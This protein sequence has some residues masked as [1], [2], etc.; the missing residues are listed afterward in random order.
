MLLSRNE[1]RMTVHSVYTSVSETPGISVSGIGPC[2]GCR[3]RNVQCFCNVRATS[4]DTAC[5][6]AC[7][8]SSS[9]AAISS[10]VF[11]D[12]TIHGTTSFL[13][14]V[15][16][17]P[18][19]T[20]DAVY[21]SLV[22]EGPAAIETLSVSGA[23]QA[24]GGAVFY[25]P[26][27]LD[28]GDSSGPGFI[29]GTAPSGVALTVF[30]NTNLSGGSLWASDVSASGALSVM[31]PVSLGGALSVSGPVT[32]GDSLA[33]SSEASFCGALGVSGTASFSGSFVVSGTALVTGPLTLSGGFGIGILE[34]SAVS[35]TYLSAQTISAA[36]AQA[37]VFTMAEGDVTM[38]LSAASIY[39][40]GTAVFQS[41]V[42]VESTLAVSGMSYLASANVSGTSCFAGPVKVSGGLQVVGGSL[43]MGAGQ[44]LNL[45][46]SG[47]SLRLGTASNQ[48]YF[49]VQG[50]AVP[51][52][53]DV[54]GG[55]LS[56]LTAYSETAELVPDALS[57]YSGTPAMLTL[58]TAG[59]YLINVAWE[60]GPESDSP[61]FTAALQ[62]VVV[63]FCPQGTTAYLN[64]K[65]LGFSTT[66]CSGIGTSYLSTNDT[67]MYACPPTSSLQ[68]FPQISIQTGAGTAGLVYQKAS[69]IAMRFC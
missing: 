56:S 64:Q 27:S 14:S 13:G 39:V 68:I 63:G 65:T 12:V 23:L 35:T 37:T 6:Y 34:A 22:V 32:F 57:V 3:E 52:T 31:G 53:A 25:P 9:Q 69:M 19:S 15:T 46:G 7:G 47:A 51:V 48:V 20:G 21:T 41:T 55:Q 54:L 24:G 66:M 42:E 28:S 44:Q 49:P 11:G 36:A 60:V 16:G 1:R 40:S 33:V 18:S 45:S 43:D 61:S 38:S 59:S 8:L 5:L 17:L 30:G 50:G 29:S 62:N 67:F 58:P 10:A 26:N 4:I 2:I